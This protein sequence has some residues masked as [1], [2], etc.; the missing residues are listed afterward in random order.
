MEF[1]N[2]NGYDVKDKKAI[3]FYN[4]VDDMKNDSTLKEGMSVITKGYYSV[5]DGGAS[6]YHITSIESNTEYQE[7]ISNNLYATLV[8]TDYVTPEMFG[9]KGNNT[10]NDRTKVIFFISDGEITDES[11]LKSYKEIS[12]YINGGAVLG[13]GTTQGGYM[14]YKEMFGSEKENY[15]MYYYPGEGYSKAVSKIDESNLKKIAS[16]LKVDYI[17]M[18]NESDI[19]RKLTSIKNKT[20]LKAS[21]MDK[22]SY[23]DI[24]YIFIIPLLVL[25]VLDFNK[26][27][28]KFI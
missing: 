4:T 6:M 22:S 11:S 8:I 5:N 28:R 15:L 16:D 13:Y 1:I 25:M 26:I 19:D 23:D 9:A 21:T 17:K 2:L 3:R 14:K 7:E 27:R 10:D 12:K 24:Y 18:N 20:D